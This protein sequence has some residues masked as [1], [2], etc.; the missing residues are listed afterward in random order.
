M[1]SSFS[2][3]NYLGSHPNRKIVIAE[4]LLQMI[5]IGSSNYPNPFFRPTAK[6]GS[7]APTARTHPRSKYDFDLG[8][9]PRSLLTNLD[10][11]QEEN[12]LKQVIR[13]QDELSK[14]KIK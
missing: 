4:C 2:V 8:K 5:S 6:P 1:T 3:M 11:K 9:S 14:E 7:F 13:L 12:L 10:D